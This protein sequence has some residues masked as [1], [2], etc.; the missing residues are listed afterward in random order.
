MK[1]GIIFTL[2]FVLITNFPPI[3]HLAAYAKNVVYAGQM[4]STLR[5]S[6]SPNPFV[7]NFSVETDMQ[8]LSLEVFTPSGDKIPSTIYRYHSNGKIKYETGSDLSSGI[9]LVRLSTD[10]YAAFFKMIKID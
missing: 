9:Y 4:E 6:L 7:K 3:P 5:V 1:N 8:D 2:L 10:D